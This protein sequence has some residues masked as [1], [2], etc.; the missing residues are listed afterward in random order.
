MASAEEK[1]NVAKKCFDEVVPKFL[2]N[3]EKALKDGD[4]KH[5]AGSSVST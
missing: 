5:F 2:A 3:C 4:G 1:P